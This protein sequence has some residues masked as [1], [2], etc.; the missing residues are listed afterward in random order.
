MADLSDDTA[1]PARLKE[2]GF[3]PLLPSFFLVEGLLMYLPRP[4]VPMLF[5]SISALMTKNSILAGDC[6]MNAPGGKMSELLESYGTQWVFDVKKEA[7]LKAMLSNAAFEANSCNLYD[8]RVTETFWS[9]TESDVPE[10][11]DYAHLAVSAVHSA[12]SRLR[13]L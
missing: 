1:W 4:A 13:G 3:N 6:M 2:A 12:V 10:S 8:W 11:L 7:D 9:R 5:R